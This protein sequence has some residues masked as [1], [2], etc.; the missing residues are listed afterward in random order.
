MST[1]KK[2]FELE[3]W[4][5]Y[6]AGDDSAKVQLLGSLQPVIKSQ[7]NRFRNSG[8]PVHALELEGKRLA[9]IALNSFDPDKAQLNTHVM[10]NLKKLSRFSTTYQNIGHIPEP[11]V[12]LLGKYNTVYANLEDELGREP[13]INELADHMHVPPAE[14][15]RLQLELRNDL[16]ME[17]P[18]D[19]AEEGGFFMYVAP[20]MEDPK[21]RE[22][23]EFVYFDA[24]PINKKIMEYRIPGIGGSEKLTD[25]QIKAKLGLT[26]TEY[27]KRRN[28]IA[29]QIKELI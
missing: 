7:V 8:L 11:R 14:I 19:D 17:L 15:N 20:D 16:Q 13:T 23:I 21:K 12:L 3:L 2:Q 25:T 5:Q 24:D 18:A 1:D 10:N 28:Q 4:R 22:A 9:N 26:E 29:E 6:K 27:K